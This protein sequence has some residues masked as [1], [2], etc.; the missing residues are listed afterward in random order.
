MFG[1]VLYSTHY[2]E[3]N[4]LALQYWAAFGSCFTV[5]MVLCLLT[6]DNTRSR[7]C[8]AWNAKFGLVCFVIGAALLF[9][10]STTGKYVISLSFD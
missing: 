1:H 9:L 7:S 2:A 6:L 8:Q 3:L 4:Y 10:Y 5:L